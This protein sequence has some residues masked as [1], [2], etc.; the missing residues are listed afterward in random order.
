MG[1]RSY[2]SLNSNRSTIARIAAHESWA[3]T[4]DRAARTAPARAG[5]QARFIREAREQ[6][7]ANATERQVADAAE[8]A[9]RAHYARL[10]MA[11]VT[12]RR[13]GAR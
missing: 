9:R 6:L 10:S 1:Y 3:R 5:L 2:M 12:A 4:R 7:G 13:A 11:G 8:S